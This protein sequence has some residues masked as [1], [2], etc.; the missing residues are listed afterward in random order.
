MLLAALLGVGACAPLSTSGASAPT[1][2][3]SAAASAAPSAT[4]LRSPPPLP[5]AVGEQR[6]NGARAKAHLDQLADPARGGRM[7]GSPGYAEA[8]AY[9]AT[10][11]AEA[12]F[13]PLGD[14]GTYLQKFRMPFVDLA[15][16]PALE[17][18]G[19][20]GR[21]YAHRR[22]FTEI[23]GGRA[24]SGSV[25]GRIVFVGAAISTASYNDFAGVNVRG[26]V[27]L[28][29][30]GATGVDPLRNAIAE[31]A[32][33]AI[34]IGTSGPFIKSSYIARFESE[35][36]PTVLVTEAVA[37][38]LLAASGRRAGDLRRATAERVRAVS[39]QT[40]ISP[41]PSL[42]FEAGVTIHLAVPLVP[43]REIEAANVV[44]ILHGTDPEAARRAVVVGGHLDGVGTD[45]DGTVFPAANDNASGPA[46][47][48][49][50]AR[51]L[52]ETKADLRRSVI[53]VLFA[54]EEQ[55]LLG[56][57]AFLERMSGTPWAAGNLVAFL[58]LDVVGC[59]GATLSASDEDGALA[60]RVRGAAER[61]GIPFRT[62]FRGSSDQV[63]FARQRVPAVMI[64][65]ADSG[66]LHTTRD[67]AST[68]D[69]AHLGDAGRVA[70]AVIRELAAEGR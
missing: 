37:D 61:E 53:V 50:L 28:L 4:P 17:L 23:I 45:P 7:S 19:P 62:G 63:S 1:A 29:F 25:I 24:G 44:G 59:C 11:L 27:V 16:T 46:I 13:A 67:T 60:D 66:A 26:A 58:N 54:G 55:G 15:A 43:V 3:L 38:E 64:A 5:F 42:S 30:G 65:W 14:E 32:A 41:Q 35:T 51:A 57:R 52:R 56:S 68:V 69:A 47:A 36:V 22:E 8:A 40:A 18:R 49:E 48:L 39:G 9:S 34:V 31:G 10:R 6:F 21:S 20:L 12:G 2:G 33:G 70:L